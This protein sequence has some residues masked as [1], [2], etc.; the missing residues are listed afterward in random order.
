MSDYFYFSDES[1]E[2]KT[3]LTADDE[4]PICTRCDH[5]GDGFKCEESC[6]LKRVGMDI[7]EQLTNTKEDTL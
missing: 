2:T 3:Y 6:G 1:L 7:S 5:F 4:D